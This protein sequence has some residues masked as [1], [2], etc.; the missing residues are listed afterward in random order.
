MT[1]AAPNRNR[2]LICAMRWCFVGIAGL[3]MLIAVLY[4][5]TV[6]LRRAISQET[7]L[8]DDLKLENAKLKNSFYA[9]LDTRTL[10][11]AAERLGY[12]RD[13]NP[14]YLTFRADGTA[15]QNDSS[16]SIKP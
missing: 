16:V 4:N 13:N 7:K 2:Q 14:S 15:A 6:S 12:V 1:I 8:V 9:V 3:S 11:A 10:V 5:Q